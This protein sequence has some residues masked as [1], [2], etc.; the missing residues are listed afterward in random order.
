MSFTEI[1]FAP[2]AILTF[3]LFFFLRNRPSAQIVL[4]V[5]ASYV[6]Y[7]WW[8]IAFVWLILFSSVLDFVIGHLIAG[9]NTPLR[10]RIYLGIS[11]VGN[12]GL[13]GYFKYANFF[14]HSVEGGLRALG[15]DLGWPA[16][17]IVLPVG[18]SF[19]TF[20]SLS[21][22]LDIYFGRIKPEKSF[23]R[24]LFFVAAFPQLVAGPI[25]RAR[26]FLPQLRGN[27]FSRSD[28]S[29]L[30]YIFYG[31]FKKIMVADLLGYYIV[32]G[33][34]HTPHMYS[35]AEL[36]LGV[37]AYAF[38]IFFD[39]SAYSDIAIGLGKVFGLTL[40]VNFRSPYLAQSPTDFWRRWHITLS[41]WLRDYLYIP[42]GGNRVGPV[43][44]LLNLML[45]MLLG[46]L[47]HGAHW[48]FVVWGGLH[49]LYLVAHKV[50]TRRLPAGRLP[51]WIQRGLFFHLVCLTW[52]FFRSENF[53]VAG[54]YLRS[55]GRMNVSL[56]NIPA[57][58][59]LILLVVAWVFHDIVE[60]RLESVSRKFA[61]LP[62]W[63]QGSLLYLLL[64]VFSL[65]G[66]KGIAHQAFIYFQF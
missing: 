37:Y 18:I 66:Q 56:N 47:W 30:F 4:L 45:V 34:F 46:G 64:A 41:T 44:H 60:P 58:P 52:I 26:D 3:I 23:V 62:W 1:I 6:F 51:G 5:F 27:L 65:L 17:N 20:Q 14:V 57:V 38:Q 19:Y 50:L 13:L 40:P 2:F 55:L 42:L 48:T 53:A 29:G 39:F 31:V 32:D 11:L 25:V 33:V 8:K 49:G 59:V 9:T 36:L 15:M 35:S 61:A 7:G 24:F 28:H 54:Q 21:Y 12:L 43:R 63:L 10:R 16:L 22:S